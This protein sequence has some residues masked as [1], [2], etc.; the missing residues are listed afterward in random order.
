MT[1]APLLDCIGTPFRPILLVAWALY[2]IQSFTA[3]LILYIGRECD[4]MPPIPILQNIYEG[5]PD[6]DRSRIPADQMPAFLHIVQLLADLNF[7]ERN[8]LLACYLYEYSKTAEW[9]LRDDFVRMDR[10]G[11]TTGGWQSMA[12]RDG[13]MTIYHFG[14]AVEGLRESFRFCQA[15]GDQ[16]DHGKIRH[17]YK[18]FKG[19]FPHFIEI[20]A[21]VAHVADFSQ[22]MRKKFVHSIKGIFQTKWFSSGDPVGTTWLPGNMNERTFAVTLGGKPYTYDLTLENAAKLREIK[23]QIFSAFEAATTHKA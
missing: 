18:E 2:S 10:A 9:E 23:L 17:C 13:A 5:I 20:R 22:T 14:R 8:L 21:A 1:F 11:W 4:F 19:A 16:V 6:I 7:Y 12:A 3:F 15:L